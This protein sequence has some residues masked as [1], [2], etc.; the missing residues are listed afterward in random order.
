MLQGS[1]PDNTIEVLQEL[2]SVPGLHAFGSDSF[3]G[4]SLNLTR[5]QPLALTMTIYD[6]ED[7]FCLDP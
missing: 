7:P 4:L 2:H 1:V 5:R 3:G 6:N